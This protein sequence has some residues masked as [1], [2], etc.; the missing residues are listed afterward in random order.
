VTPPTAPP[1]AAA[2]PEAIAAASPADSVEVQ[3]PIGRTPLVPERSESKSDRL[4][5]PS[6]RSSADL[7][8]AAYATV[9]DRWGVPLE[10][11]ELPCDQAPR[12]GLQC[13]KLSGTWADIA[14]LDHPVVIELWDERV[15][16]YYAAVV[17]RHDGLLLVQLDSA[18]IEITADELS[19]HWYGAFIVMWQMPPDY[20]GSLRLGD[21]GPAVAWL[22]Q[23]LAAT[24]QVDL[25]TPEP[26]RFDEGLQTALV[27]FQRANGIA[28][29]GVA[30]P[31]T[32]IA[33][34]SASSA[35]MPRL[36]ARS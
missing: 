24:L 23:H 7:Q 26:D 1:P 20:R 36:N 2:P 28:P 17:G 6:A 29:D 31:L 9:F 32:W 12:V 15:D 16:P 34:N 35:A 8:R 14:R 10:P 4:A 25:R 22:R 3:S 21:S 13:L 5:R 19:T 11:T 33:M 30:G 27:R 18:P